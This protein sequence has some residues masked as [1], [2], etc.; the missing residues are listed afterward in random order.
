[1]TQECARDEARRVA[2]AAAAESCAAVLGEITALL[3]RFVVMSGAQARVVALW[4]VHTHSS[5]PPT[6]VRT[7]R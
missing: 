3:R 2:Q 7:W 5:A 6:R 4:T 1:V